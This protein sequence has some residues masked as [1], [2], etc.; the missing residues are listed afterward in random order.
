MP[1]TTVAH[2]ESADRAATLQNLAA[3]T[4]RH[5]YTSGDDLRVPALNQLVACAVGV[6]SGGSGY[7]RIDAPSL[8]DLTRLYIQPVN[9]NTD[10][11]AE[12]GSPPA[13]VD[14]RSNPVI[15]SPDEVLQAFADDNPTA[16]A[17]GWAIYWLSD[18][19]IAPVGGGRMTSVRATSATAL[20]ADAW[21]TVTPTF[22]DVLPVGNYAVIGLRAEA[23][24]LVAARLVFK[25]GT[26]PTWRPGVLG[27][28][29][30]SDINSDIF[31]FGNFGVFGEFHS[32]TPPDIE[33]ISVSADASQEFILDLV[34]L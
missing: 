33:C 25:G 34:K 6:A 23:A 22:A 8:L 29:S 15:L 14:F 16:A 19:P 24:G 4:D 20:V 5:I 27:C 17:A 2:Y 13:I 3:L 12:P 7:V 21:S 9:G 28:D 32:T 31:R 1:F 26:G 10:A 11:P 30:D 18:G